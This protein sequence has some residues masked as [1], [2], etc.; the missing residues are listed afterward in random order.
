MGYFYY[1][2]R[3]FLQACVVSEV[4]EVRWTSRLW[5]N[6]RSQRTYELSFLPSVK[7][8]HGCLAIKNG[9]VSCEGFSKHQRE[10]DLSARCWHQSE[11]HAALYPIWPTLKCRLYI[12]KNVQLVSVSHLW[13]FS[14]WS[15]RW[16]FKHAFSSV[17]W[18]ACLSSSKA[19]LTE[20]PFSN[21]E[22]SISCEASGLLESNLVTLCESRTVL[23]FAVKRQTLLNGFFFSFSL[24]ENV[25][26]LVFMH[27]ED[28]DE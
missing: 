14:F 1:C 9:F 28:V 10:T 20:W 6:L 15:T 17:H 13:L 12:W 22:F 18:W 8:D 7:V 16:K 23:M 3:P 19:W 5:I 26:W 21:Q 27:L 4:F 24:W 25:L 11:W 2:F